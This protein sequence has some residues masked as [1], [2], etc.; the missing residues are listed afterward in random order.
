M[1]KSGLGKGLGALFTESERDQLDAFD[2]EEAVSKPSAAPEQRTTVAPAAAEQTS[3]EVLRTAVYPNPDQPRKHFDTT[4]LDELAS[5]IR[6]HG[7]IQP[8]VVVQ[9]GERYMIIA[10]ERRWRAAEIA[11][12]EKIPVVI[13]KYSDQRIKEIS[14]IEN[15]QRE[16]LN[17][18]EAANAIRQLMDE[19]HFT[20][21]AVADR[22]GKSRSAVANTLRL[23]SLTS[24]VVQLILTGRLSAGHARCLVV[25]TDP[26]M[27]MRLAKAAADDNLTVRDLEK[28][29]RDFLTPKEAPQRIE[30]S[31]ELKE[32]VADMQ[33]VFGTKVSAL[34]NDKKGRIY[35]DYYTR[36]D[37]DRILELVNGAKKNNKGTV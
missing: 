35:I 15:L 33:R 19:F 29:V 5:S 6:T 26:V 17:P 16:D 23:L 25:I 21:E 30:Q 1:K 27:Q 31:V 32:L 18:I 12:L 20:Q 9:R 8:V 13:K 36:D 2:M 10:G 37:L 3:I 4:A 11:G 28:A 7:I 24:E 34:G 14:L 22:L